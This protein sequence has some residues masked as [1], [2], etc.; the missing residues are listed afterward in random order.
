MGGLATLPS[1]PSYSK[2][3]CASHGASASLSFA[4]FPNR[5]LAFQIT[6]F[7]MKQ[8]LR[9]LP[10]KLLAPLG[11]QLIRRSPNRI[12]MEAALMRVGGHNFP[13]ATVIDIGA[14]A[15]KWSQMALKAFPNAKI[16]AV[17][18]LQEREAE[19]RG[20]AGR[21]PNFDYALCVAGEQDGGEATLNVSADLDGSTV[22]GKGGEART[23][24]IRSLDGLLAE[25]NC[26]APTL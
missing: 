2:I 3:N 18:P 7:F 8:Y 4:A 19:L 1:E 11:F 5:P 16:L 14:A 13:I 26:L 23:V 12:E 10:N 15:G 25:K 22:E 20:L 24:P 9:S 21:H 17:E 6:S